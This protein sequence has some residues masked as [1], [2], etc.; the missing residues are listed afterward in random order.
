MGFCW[1]EIRFWGLHPGRN[2]HMFIILSGLLRR[3]TPLIVTEPN[4]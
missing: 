4:G 1:I 3:W 2:T